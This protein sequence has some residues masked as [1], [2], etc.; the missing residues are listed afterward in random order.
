MHV[1]PPF[2]TTPR[3]CCWPSQQNKLTAVTPSAHQSVGTHSEH[4]HEHAGQHPVKRLWLAGPKERLDSTVV[5]QPA[6]YVASLAA[7][8]Q[9]RQAEGEVRGAG[10]CCAAQT[11]LLA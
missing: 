8:E 7:V 3:R 11:L 1:Q 2:L 4:V 5:S 6:I 9:L 10:A